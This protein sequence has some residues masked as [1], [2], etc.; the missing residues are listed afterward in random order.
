MKRDVRILL[1]GEGEGRGGHGG[2]GGFSSPERERGHGDPGGESSLAEQ[3]RGRAAGQ[4]EPPSLA[5]PGERP[6]R[7]LGVIVTSP[8]SDRGSHLPLS[9]QALPCQCQRPPFIS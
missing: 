2:G 6:G 8:G 1:L 3:D 7:P 5:R 4:V 9:P